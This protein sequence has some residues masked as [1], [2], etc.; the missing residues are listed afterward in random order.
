[1]LAENNSAQCDNLSTVRA[2][3]LEHF[4]PEAIKNCRLALPYRP[5]YPPVKEIL[6]LV[7]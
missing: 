2:F 3:C 7:R 5:K 1:V 4:S 6:K